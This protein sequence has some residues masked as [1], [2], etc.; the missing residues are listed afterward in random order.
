MIK[1]D[2]KKYLQKTLVVI[3]TRRRSSTIWSP[4]WGLATCSV[5]TWTSSKGTGSRET[6]R[7]VSSGWRVFCGSEVTRESSPRERQRRLF[8]WQSAVVI[9]GV[10]SSLRLRI[11]EIDIIHGPE[12]LVIIL[13][14]MANGTWPGPRITL[15]RRGFVQDKIF[16]SPELEQS[17]QKHCYYSDERD[18]YLFL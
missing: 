1:L 8:Q 3:V 10:R 6:V 9:L 17:R 18:I 12:F 15:T 4:R 13:L 14:I 5:R 7:R 2:Q 11:P 16:I